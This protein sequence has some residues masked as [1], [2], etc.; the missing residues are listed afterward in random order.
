MLYFEP[1]SG[2]TQTSYVWKVPLQCTRYSTA[3]AHV[4]WCS[5]TLVQLGHSFDA[6]NIFLAALSFCNFDRTPIIGPDTVFVDSSRIIPCC[7]YIFYNV[8]QAKK[9]EI[10][11]EAKSKFGTRHVNMDGNP[12][13]GIVVL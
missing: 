11:M 9:E 7:E 12:Y 5:L 1:F 2:S 4:F 6:L 3:Q 13:D 8:K 10:C